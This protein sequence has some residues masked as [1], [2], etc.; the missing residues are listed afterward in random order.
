MAVLVSRV[1]QL[2]LLSVWAREPAGWPSQHGANLVWLS[3]YLPAESPCQGSDV[4][5]QMQ[6]TGEGTF[7]HS[8]PTLPCNL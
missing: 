7:C 5:A 1:P 4:R 6:L 3:L 8:S 2:W